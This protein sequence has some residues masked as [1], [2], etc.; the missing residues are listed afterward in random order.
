MHYL[1][2]RLS[3]LYFCTDGLKT[4]NDFLRKG[5][6]HYDE[7]QFKQQIRYMYQKHIIGLMVKIKSQLL[8]LSNQIEQ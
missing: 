3:Y 6:L 4:T 8:K 7:Q 5:D 2:K 1:S